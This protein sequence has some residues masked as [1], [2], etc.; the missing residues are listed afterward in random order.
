MTVDNGLLVSCGMIEVVLDEPCEGCFEKPIRV[1]FPVPKNRECNICRIQ[2]V[3]NISKNGRWT[4]SKN[5][6]IKKVKVDGQ[7]FYEMEIKCPGR[8]NCDC[9]L[10]SK[11]VVFKFPRRFKVNK[12]NVVYNCPTANYVFSAKKNK[13]KGQLP[14]KLTGKE[15]F[16][17]CSGIYGQDTIKL[18]RIPLDEFNHS[19]WKNCKS[20]RKENRFWIFKRWKHKTYSKYRLRKRRIK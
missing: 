8:R 17:Y 11:D 20:G 7:L 6:K 16:V 10:K 12:L 4:E 3:Y 5:S 18:E 15:A 1:K 9:P 14:C 19:V 2:R 13:A